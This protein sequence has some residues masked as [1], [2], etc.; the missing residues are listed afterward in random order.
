M[1]NSV[2]VLAE[3]NS[4]ES[5]A[6]A[7]ASLYERDVDAVG[8]AARTRVLRQFTWNK[9]FQAQTTV[10][11]SLAGIRRAAPVSAQSVIELRSAHD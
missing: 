4:G 10:Y 9:A 2:G 11:A 5:M 7:I 3:P 6:E 1:D 8:A